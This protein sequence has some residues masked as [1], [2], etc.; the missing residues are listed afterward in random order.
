MTILLVAGLGKVG[1]GVWTQAHMREPFDYIGGSDSTGF[2]RGKYDKELVEKI[3]EYKENGGKLGEITGDLFSELF[4]HGWE[5]GNNP[6]YLLKG[7]GPGLLEGE[8][9]KKTIFINA[10]QTK[11]TLEEKITL[12]LND[13]CASLQTLESHGLMNV[14]TDVLARKKGATVIAAHKQWFTDIAIWEYMQALEDINHTGSV[15]PAGSIMGPTIAYLPISWLKENN[16]NLVSAEGILNGTCNY[17]LSK[18]GEGMTEIEALDDAILKGIPEPNPDEDLLGDDAL[19]KAKILA[20]S[21]DNYSGDDLFGISTLLS[22]AEIAKYSKS[23][24]VSPE[25]FRSYTGIKGITLGLYKAFE[26]QGKYLKL[27]CKINAED[28]IANV[29]PAALDKDNPLAKIYGTTNALTVFTENDFDLDNLVREVYGEAK[30][31][32]SFNAT[33]SIPFLKKGTLHSNYVISL[34]KKQVNGLHSLTIIG[35]GAEPFMTAAGL[36]TVANNIKGY[37][38]KTVVDKLTY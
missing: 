10:M 16:A 7:I 8:T 3:L 19:G 34:K 1:R 21:M 6:L 31:S 13:Q 25:V 11:F 12:D 33:I 32:D 26:Q 18:I 15:I 5:L 29:G 37:I 23:L 24:N 17:I 30:Y 28:G 2:V 4:N 35:A 9:E 27:V 22:N 36:L 20:I 38:P 14:Y